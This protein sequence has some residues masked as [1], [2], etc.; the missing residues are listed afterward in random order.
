MKSKNLLVRLLI[1]AKPYWKAFI[2]I[3]T[4]MFTLTCVDLAKPLIMR[5]SIDLFVNVKM[6]AAEKFGPL[7]MYGILYLGLLIAGFGLAVSQT[8]LLQQVGQKIIKK[9]RGDVYE[10]IMSLPSKYY[11]NNA[12]GALVTRVAND[13]ENLN[14]LYTNVI[15]NS[16]KHFLYLI[17]VMCMLFYLD[18][19]VGLFV[20]CVVPIM[21]VFTFVFRYFS[22]RAYRETRTYTTE[23]NI[24][25]SEHIMGMKVVQI[26]NRQWP[27]FKKMKGINTN[28]YK[29]GL[30]ELYTFSIFR[31]LLFV[32]SQITVAIVLYM[33]ATE[34]LAGLLTVG[35]L[36]ALRS[37]ASDF[38]GPIEQ[39]A[40]VYNTLQSAVASG[41]KIFSIL[42]EENDIVSG[43]K[44]IEKEIFQAKIEFK[45]VWF[46]YKEGED[47]L[48]D[49]SF[50]IE[51]GQKVAF[52]GATGAGKTTILALIG[53]YYDIY[54]GQILIDGVDI[55]EYSIDSL[56]SQIGQVLQ[57]VFLFTG[58]IKGN[59]HLGNEKITMDTVQNASKMVYAD[60]FIQELG[61]K[62]DEPVVEG[63]ATLSTGQRQ[64]ISFARAV[65]YDPK[66]FI[67]DEATSNIDTHTEAVIQKA[68]FKMME[69]RT[70][71]M[72]AHR[73]S[74]I[75][76]SDNIIVLEKGELKEMGTHSQL[77][78]KGGIYFNLYELSKKY[79]VME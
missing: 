59:I 76:H 19:R 7:I 56:R 35:S 5:T 16:L 25:L 36:I 50:V 37:Y 51:P 22:I 26:F 49:V 28:L 64:L 66:I 4:L 55:R 47:I 69:G 78:E 11:D 13:T 38:F 65:S 3:F 77:L 43:E 61:E 44:E 67:L 79:Q 53:R 8:L 71:I 54:K 30:K 14:Q 75:Q 2:L 58:D 17:G 48:K 42:D 70:T 21:L 23:M 32:T 9:I 39:L 10:K 27:T 31:P 62:Y 29:A 12:V 18:A 15:T 45:N 60:D 72:V 63:G 46:A 68:L 6:P 34:V 41:E 74:T 1:Y 52:V 40:D 73:L 20:L 57:D 33:G 24:F